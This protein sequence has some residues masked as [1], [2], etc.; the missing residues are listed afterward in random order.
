MSHRGPGPAHQRL[1]RHRR[2]RGGIGGLHLV[3]GQDGAHDG[4]LLGHDEGD[5]HVVGVGQRQV[6]M[7]GAVALGQPGGA[8][9][10]PENGR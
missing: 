7:S 8:A 6:E 9:V 5:G 3:T 4:E 2:Q 10:Q 1:V